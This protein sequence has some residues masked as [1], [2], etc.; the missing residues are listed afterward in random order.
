MQLPVPSIG[1]ELSLQCLSQKIVCDGAIGDL[2]W[3]NGVVQWA[4]RVMYFLV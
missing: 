4:P 1:G 2:S 3:G